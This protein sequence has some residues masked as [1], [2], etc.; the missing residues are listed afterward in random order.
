MKK[1]WRY[2]AIVAATACVA[3]APA[4]IW[5]GQSSHRQS[6]AG[7]DPFV[8]KQPPLV[9][10]GPPLTAAELA[11]REREN[12]RLM[13]EGKDR[14][15]DQAHPAVDQVPIGLFPWMAPKVEPLP[16][17]TATGLTAKELEKFAMMESG[18]LQR[19]KDPGVWGPKPEPPIEKLDVPLRPLGLEGL[20]AQE[21]AKLEASRRAVKPESRTDEGGR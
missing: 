1:Y 9:T 15:A 16:L 7:G 10:V 18:A 5:S 11:A 19:G 6:A 8:H 2:V 13:L 20:T 3:L 4:L 12:A 17:T 21:K 14:V